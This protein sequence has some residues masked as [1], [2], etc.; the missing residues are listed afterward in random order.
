M[1]PV[2]GYE[3][4]IYFK[5]KEN[6]IETDPIGNVYSIFQN[7]DKCMSTKYIDYMPF[8]T[9]VQ[10]S[11]KVADYVLLYD[12]TGKV[13]D[14]FR[15]WRLASLLNRGELTGV[16]K[17]YLLDDK[18]QK[19]GTFVTIVLLENISTEPRN[20]FKLCNN[21]DFGGCEENVVYNTNMYDNRS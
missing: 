2:G 6:I 15:C 20:T 9:M 3:S 13:K 16:V 4:L 19:A 10:G 17:A 8:C 21:A 11:D 1:Y 14:K 5:N 12:I 18:G 7:I